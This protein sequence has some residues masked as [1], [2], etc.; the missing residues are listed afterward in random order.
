MIL[1]N[2][3]T[4]IWKWEVD[5]LRE[6]VR[7]ATVALPPALAAAEADSESDQASR[8]SDCAEESELHL[9]LQAQGPRLAALGASGYADDT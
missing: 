8:H 5:A 7:M 9:Q 3:L 1:V 6:Q 4:T 2:V